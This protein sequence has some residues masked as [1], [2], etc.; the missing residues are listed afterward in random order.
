MLMKAAYWFDREESMNNRVDDRF[1]EIKEL[2]LGYQNIFA[3]ATFVILSGVEIKE[4]KASKSRKVLGVTINM[5][6][7]IVWLSQNEFLKNAMT[8]AIYIV[9]LLILSY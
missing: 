1:K 6:L 7:L 9:S 8:K 5:A 2:V 3:I 4:L